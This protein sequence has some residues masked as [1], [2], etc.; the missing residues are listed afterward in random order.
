[1]RILHLVNSR[2]LAGSERVVL[3]LLR[4]QQDAGA[5]VGVVCK[6]SGEL[7]D[8]VRETAAELYT[9]EL[10]WPLAGYRLS[11]IMRRFRPDILHAHLTQSAR[12]AVSAVQRVPAGLVAHAHIFKSDPAYTEIARR[13][14]LL[15]VSRDVARFFEEAGSLPSG[16]VPVIYNGTHVID[17]PEAVLPVETARERVHALLGLPATAR[18]VTL[19][20]RGCRQKGQDLLVEAAGR[21]R[22]THPDLH[23]LLAESFRHEQAWEHQ[24]RDLASRLGLA[25]RVHLWGFRDDTPLLIRAADVHVVPSRYDP[26]SL[27]ALEGIGLAA[28]VIVADTGGL[29][30]MI[31]PGVDGLSVPV[32]DPQAL[33]DALARLLDSPAEARRL[34]AAAQAKVRE[35]Y[36]VEAMH[37]GVM[38]QY[39]AVLA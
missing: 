17:L 26:F 24:I 29:A 34:G 12:A 15:A 36:T 11:R 16:A 6:G 7:A 9:A 10:S 37:E 27:V 32:E 8:R 3:T 4:R 1:M 38:A 39:R 30:E 25:D 35:R 28:P 21:L 22:D 13:G 31:E 19:C 18:L 14:R 20:G 5:T 33:A 2:R 23:L